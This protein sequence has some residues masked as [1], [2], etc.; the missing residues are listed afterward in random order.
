MELAIQEIAENNPNFSVKEN[1]EIIENNNNVFCTNEVCNYETKEYKKYIL[2]K[3]FLYEGKNQYT[4]F[5]NSIQEYYKFI[6]TFLTNKLN[7]NVCQYIMTFLF[8]D[9]PGIIFK[10]SK[11]CC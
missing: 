2:S 5:L 11:T 1:L 8:K 4:Y 9:L 7:N 6:N 3:L 10:D